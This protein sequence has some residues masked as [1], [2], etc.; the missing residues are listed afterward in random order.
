MIDQQNQRAESL[1]EVFNR[2]D[3]DAQDKLLNGVKCYDFLCKLVDIKNDDEQ[4]A[5]AA[6]VT[7]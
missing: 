5:P 2:I 7:A 3:D 1:L 4:N 6:A